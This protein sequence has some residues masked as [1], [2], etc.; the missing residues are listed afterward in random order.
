MVVV[1]TNND[2]QF[3]V[4][5]VIAYLSMSQTRLFTQTVT[6]SND[7]QHTDNLSIV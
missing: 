4:F 3:F 5:D 6:K 2:L 7:T 1:L